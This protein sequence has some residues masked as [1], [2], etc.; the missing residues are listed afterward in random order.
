MM[1]PGHPGHP[2]DLKRETE[3]SDL[4][5]RLIGCAMVRAVA[6]QDMRGVIGHAASPSLPGRAQPVLRR[7]RW[8]RTR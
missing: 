8:V 3:K 7:R 5:Q 1:H 2:E 6:P 4:D